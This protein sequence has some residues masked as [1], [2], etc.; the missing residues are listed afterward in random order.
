MRFRESKIM[1]RLL[2]FTLLLLTLSTINACQ[3]WSRTFSQPPLA[4]NIA[5]LNDQTE[6]E[7]VRDMII[8]TPLPTFTPTP[9]PTLTSTLT[10]AGVIVSPTRTPTRIRTQTRTPTSTATPSQRP[11][12][13][14]TPDREPTAEDVVPTLPPPPPP[15]FPPPPPTFPPPPPPLPT[16]DDTDPPDPTDPQP[17]TYIVN[18]SDDVDDGRC[19]TRHCS[20]RE[21]I[22]AANSNS[23][24]EDFIGFDIP[25]AGP[26]TIRPNSNLPP[27][28]DLLNIDGTTQAGASCATWPPSLLIELDGTNAGAFASGLTL[29]ASDSF[30]VGLV[31]NRYAQNGITVES[32]ANNF[33]ECNFIGTDTSGTVNLGNGRHGTGFYNVNNSTIGGVSNSE[34]NLI[35]GNGDSGI[36]MRNG[37]YSNQIQGNVIGLDVNGT[38]VLGN[39]SHG[40]FMINSPFN[41]IG[42][43][44]TQARN[45]ISDNDGN[46]II[47]EG[48]NAYNNEILGN[49][50]GTDVNGTLGL[51]NLLSGILLVNASTNTIGNLNN[52]N[53]ISANGQHGVAI[54]GATA[55]SNKVSGNLIGTDINGSTALGNAKSGVNIISAPNNV[56]GD[57]LNVT[58]TTCPTA[59][60][61]ISGNG[62][63]GV[64]IRDSS[65]TGNYV[66]AN[67][68]GTTSD[69]ITPLAN[70]L[71]GVMINGATLN[72]IGGI[73][74]DASNTIANN[75][76]DGVRIVSA[77]TTNSTQNPIL[78]NAIFQNNN[79]GI[80][81]NGEGITANDG[82]GDADTGANEL[83][84]FPLLNTVSSSSGG[85]TII[86]ARL[87]SAP[88]SIFRLEF[89]ANTACNTPLGNGEGEV[90][91]GTINVTTDALGQV[92]FVTGF[93]VSLPNSASVTATA[94]DANGNTSEFSACQGVTPISPLTLTVNTND[95][96]NDGVCSTTHCSLREAIGASNGNSSAQD[97]IEFDA[98]GGAPGLLTINLTQAL[99]TITD[100]VII[101]GTT[102]PGSDC[103]T[104][105]PTL[106]V[107]LKG[108]NLSA[109]G[110][111]ISGL[112]VTAGNSEI[113]GLIINS[114]SGHGI[115]L[116]SAGNN[117]LECN[118]I[119][120]DNSST[121]FRGNALHGIY[122]ENIPANTIGGVGIG[123]SNLI[124][125]N[126][127][128]GILIEGSNATT[129]TVQ[130]NFIG[131][132]V[133]GTSGMGNAR[134][135]VALI[136]APLNTIG[137]V[138][139]FPSSTC[140][141][142][143]NLISDN[144]G[145][146]LSLEGANSQSNKVD[147][148]TIGF[149]ISHSTALGNARHGVFIA[150]AAADN[151]IGGNAPQSGNVIANNGASGVAIASAA[152]I[153][154]PIIK[155]SI[156]NHAAGLGIDLRNDGITATNDALDPDTGPN[157]LQ[158]YPLIG[159]ITS[160]VFTTITGTINSLPNTTFL[161]QLFI[162]TP[163]TPC[164]SSGNGEGEIYLGPPFGPSIITVT[165]DASGDG[166]FTATF[167]PLLPSGLAVTALATDP[168][169][170]TSEFSPCMVTP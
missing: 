27:I 115:H 34:R 147:G 160:G 139:P 41:V 150:A 66:L 101:D 121:A 111:T 48:S 95:D 144:G 165:T 83:Q 65:A 100:P 72:L 15:T 170:N 157:N 4:P 90:F 148:N 136:D 152:S 71:N 153:N 145:H 113:R 132:D 6:E 137:G 12:L 45:L 62:E 81:L 92:D 80:D 96:S 10:I 119:G 77:G 135:G 31:I 107:E 97:T 39:G 5:R 168:N 106:Q 94:T 109:S 142:V 29:L 69:G 156:F 25:G 3:L 67:Y 68:I 42:G 85:I 58:G 123:T 134:S 161:I 110:A 14:K 32:A 167:T 30:I 76:R 70:A 38:S 20:L 37:S 108:S 60:N 151:I 133:N 59:C 120:T 124:A 8:I 164:H 56:I 87:E 126:D 118:F 11:T 128:Y 13:T 122:I 131:T 61:L 44:S 146:G 114:F 98:F 125:D 9:T 82:V 163:T 54:L 89:F 91:I 104:W 93:S 88:S 75:G 84:N 43:T 2:G 78:G 64:Q 19:D 130:G 63:H 138:N 51:G 23:P 162:N 57:A 143:C 112:E 40:I 149:D 1:N 105:P 129:N 102:Q 24:A 22:N 127:G 16:D 28:T 141:G 154:N 158:N 33:I 49:Y 155:N 35:S 79:L 53:I 73:S 55:N 99:P 17:T 103:S 140:S 36:L 21:A 117:R 169:G 7:L 74:T 47:I 26:Y 46:G 18:A 166:S 86:D 50:I 159:G 52:P 116:L